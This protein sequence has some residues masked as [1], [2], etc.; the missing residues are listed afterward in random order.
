MIPRLH[1]KHYSRNL[2]TAI[3]CSLSV[4]IILFIFFPGINGKKEKI[5]VPPELF[6]TDDIPPTIQPNV[7]SGK[8]FSMPEIPDI[9]FSEISSRIE[10]LHDVL[11]GTQNN[12]HKNS[13]N[14]NPTKNNRGSGD[15]PA[16]QPRQIKEVLPEKTFE[17][18]TGDIILSL[19]IGKDGKVE[20]YILLANTTDSEEC[21]RNV[22]NAVKESRWQVN[23]INGREAE[24]WIKKEYHFK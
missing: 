14:L 6:S 11:I 2:K 13:E 4:I 19:K 10:M 3:I 12:L 8:K 18:I 22:L 15:S 17:K 5:Y 20:K 24:Y 1:D 9:K 21:L 16:F 23:K 7:S